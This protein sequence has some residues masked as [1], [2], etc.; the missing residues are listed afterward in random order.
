MSLRF[1]RVICRFSGHKLVNVLMETI[2]Q[3]INNKKMI[4]GAY[5]A[6]YAKARVM[7]NLCQSWLQQGVTINAYN[8]SHDRIREH[9]GYFLTHTQIMRSLLH[10]CHC[11]YWGPGFSR[12]ALAFVT[13]LTTNIKAHGFLQN[14]TCELCRVRP[15][16]EWTGKRVTDE[17][18]PLENNMFDFRKSIRPFKCPYPTCLHRYD[19]HDN[20]VA[21][22]KRIHVL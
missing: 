1:S 7:A 19:T 13:A 20:F 15:N 2:G 14:E 22:V 4:R 10:V 6:P 9:Y 17:C 16:D 3:R 8:E 5:G 18:L 12:E 11:T 21:H